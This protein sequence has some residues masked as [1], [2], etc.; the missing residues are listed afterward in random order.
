M[1]EPDLTDRQRSELYCAALNRKGKPCGKLGHNLAPDGRRFCGSHVAANAPDATKVPI[2]FEGRLADDSQCNTMAEQLLVMVE[3]DEPTPL[4]HFH[5]KLMQAT[6]SAR[7][8]PK[9]G[10]RVRADDNGDD[11][12]TDAEDELLGGLRTQLAAAG[13]EL[14]P[15]ILDRLK[16]MLRSD[17]VA[18]N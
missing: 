17:N 3:A 7:Q 13:P 11:D 12:L 1:G 2:R 4:C 6:G 9:R 5:A 14:G 8:K 10:R 15:L 16:R 18:A